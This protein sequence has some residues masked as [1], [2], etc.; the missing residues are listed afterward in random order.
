MTSQSCFAQQSSTPASACYANILRGVLMLMA[1]LWPFVSA[2]V[3]ID[4]GRPTPVFG[5]R[6]RGHPFIRMCRE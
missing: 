5:A 3:A 4:L 6:I 2:L 1:L